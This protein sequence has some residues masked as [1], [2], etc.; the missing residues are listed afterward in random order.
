MTEIVIYQPNASSVILHN[1]SQRTAAGPLGWVQVNQLP[2]LF[3]LKA[4]GGLGA[5]FFVSLIDKIFV[6]AGAF[7]PFVLQVGGTRGPIA[8][9]HPSG[10]YK[11]LNIGDPKTGSQIIDQIIAHRGQKPVIVMV[12]PNYSGELIALLEDIRELGQRFNAR[13]IVLVREETDDPKLFHLLG[14]VMTTWKG[15]VEPEFGEIRDEA[16]VRIPRLPADLVTQTIR[17]KTSVRDCLQKQSPGT[18]VS[19]ARAFREFVK[20]VEMIYVESF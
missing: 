8:N 14:G 1:E 6:D 19:L 7:R 5:D 10:L 2:T 17:E 4:G 18:I 12:D 16:V 20:A 15:L 9:S 11:Y 3:L 13:G